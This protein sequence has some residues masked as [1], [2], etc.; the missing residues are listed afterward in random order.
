MRLNGIFENLPENQIKYFI[1]SSYFHLTKAFEVLNKHEI[2][3]ANYGKFGFNYQNQ[4]ILFDFERNLNDLDHLPLER[5]VIAFLEKNQSYIS[6]SRENIE[7]ICK[8]F[9]QT[10]QTQE[11]EK[12]NNKLYI[13]YKSYKSYKSYKNKE[14]CMKL[15]I[16]LI[17]KPKCNII[18][19]M[20]K[21]QY[22]WDMYS[23]NMLYS[24][25]FTD[26]YTF[27]H[28]ICP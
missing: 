20:E 18:Q 8:N 22:N 28:L 6:L 15:L 17:N 21:T 4:P 5:H 7:F 2:I 3:Y 25:L 10:Q 12:L 19:E 14:D 24:K 23:L 16:P 9:L 13:P 27:S 26:V 1:Y 11:I